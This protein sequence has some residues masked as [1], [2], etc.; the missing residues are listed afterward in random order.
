MSLL[1]GLHEATIF[2]DPDTPAGVQ[3]LGSTGT[4]KATLTEEFNGPVDVR[5]EGRGLVAFRKNGPVWH[6]RH[7]DYLFD[8]DFGP[9][10]NYTGNPQ[11]P[12]QQVYLTEAV[13]TAGGNLLLTATKFTEN[14][15]PWKGFRYK[16]GTINSQLSHN[17]T[18]GWFEA[19]MKLP[20]GVCQWPAF[21]LFPEVWDE[22]KQVELDIMECFESSTTVTAW[23]Q[24]P[25]A[26]V[27]GVTTNVGDVTAWHTYG[28]HWSASAVEW[29]VD[30]AL[31]ATETN[32]AAV[33]QV[34][35]YVILNLAAR[36]RAS[37]SEYPASMVTQVDYVRCWEPA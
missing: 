13:S 27:T 22:S 1:T 21:W 28:L 26:T 35:M 32:A 7:A 23:N 3:P 34:P 31:V 2:T 8:P 25:D 36:P 33:P 37:E 6:T 20:G 24:M 12:E 10:N 18:F 14:P 4:W 19:R 15:A 30:G 17:Q 16:S 5:H 29:Y 9:Q 11:L